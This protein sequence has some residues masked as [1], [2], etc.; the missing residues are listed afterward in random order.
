MRITTNKVMALA[1]PMPLA[2]ITPHA[3][4]Q[5]QGSALSLQSGVQADEQQHPGRFPILDTG[6]MFDRD[7]AGCTWIAVI[8]GRPQI[9]TIFGLDHRRLWAIGDRTGFQ[10]NDVVAIPRQ[11]GG[12]D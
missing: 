11:P 12:M 4:G 9:N 10:D 2:P 1:L 6:G 3:T 7:D 8:R 5:W